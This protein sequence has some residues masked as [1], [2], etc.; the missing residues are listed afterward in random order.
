MHG[1]GLRPILVPVVAAL[2]GWASSGPAQGITRAVRILGQGAHSPAGDA[3]PAK[4]PVS[5]P[6]SPRL[7]NH[8][9]LSLILSPSSEPP[10]GSKLTFEVSAR[11]KGYILLFDVDANG[12]LTQIYPNFFSMA[13]GEGG[14]VGESNQISAMAP[15]A[16]PGPNATGYEF[17]AS[18]P[19]GVGMTL[20]IF[21]ET[22]LEMIDLPDVPSDLVGKAEE[23]TF[24]QQAADG[25]QIVSPDARDGFQKPNFSYAAQYYVIQ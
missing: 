12:K 10:L 24:V 3:E 16:I 9:G 17:V 15:V 4:P 8:V 7:T 23:A 19:T 22:P 5:P 6:A 18:P 21:S 20:A 13:K 1:A 14:G 2:L 25:L 11:K